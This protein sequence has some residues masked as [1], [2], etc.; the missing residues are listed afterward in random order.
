MQAP[1]SADIAQV[2]SDAGSPVLVRTKANVGGQHAAL[3]QLERKPPGSEQAWSGLLC[4]RAAW[5]HPTARSKGGAQAP[6][7]TQPCN[8]RRHSAGPRLVAVRAPL[9]AR[10]A[11][12]QPGRRRRL[13]PRP[14]HRTPGR[15]PAARAQWPRA[16]RAAA[17]TR[18]PATGSGGRARAPAR[19][20]Q[21][22][23]GGPWHP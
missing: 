1:R 18:R 8:M 3:L 23:R 5:A 9:A 6:K 15:A 11:P 17:P 4:A 19:P 2:P 20:R 12:P 14:P 10:Q 22:G 13:P 7:W 16:G 21:P